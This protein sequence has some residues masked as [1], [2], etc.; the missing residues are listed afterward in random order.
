LQTITVTGAT[1]SPGES[2]GIYWDGMTTAPLTTTTTGPDGSFVTRVAVPQ[3]FLGPHLINAVGQSSAS[4]ASAVVQCRPQLLVFPYAGPPG[5]RTVVRGL[6]FGMKEAVKVFGGMPPGQL[7][8]MTTA[9][10]QGGFDAATSVTV[11][12]PLSATG[13]YPIYA[14]GQSSFGGAYALFVGR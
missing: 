8:G 2:V 10:A 6:G 9:N 3:T 5:T 7:L 13:I 4:T 12:V 1:F 14:V 11:T